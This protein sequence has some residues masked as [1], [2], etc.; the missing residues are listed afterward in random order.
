MKAFR[1][2]LDISDPASDLAPISRV[3]SDAEVF[4][5]I[6]PKALDKV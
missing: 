3:S 5:P 4:S 2:G 1:F 6:S